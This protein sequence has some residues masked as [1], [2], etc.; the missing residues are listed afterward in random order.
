MTKNEEVLSEFWC[1]SSPKK[2]KLKSLESFFWRGGGGGIPFAQV[3]TFQRLCDFRN[4]IQRAR[5]TSFCLK[6][7]VLPR[8]FLNISRTSES[9]PVFIP[10]YSMFDQMPQTAVFVDLDLN[11]K[12]GLPHISG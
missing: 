11:A 7:A 6:A 1:L 9:L 4:N 8:K 12:A 5:L 10:N 3:S 2:L